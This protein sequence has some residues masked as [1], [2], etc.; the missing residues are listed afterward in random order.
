M[1]KKISLTDK[2]ILMLRIAVNSYIEF[3]NEELKNFIDEGFS[4]KHFLVKEKN[5]RIKLLKS[6]IEKAV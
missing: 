5:E 2:E 4:K 1:A 3:E 6:I